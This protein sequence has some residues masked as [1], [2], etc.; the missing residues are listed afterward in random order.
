MLASQAL[1]HLN[2]ST[3]PQ[4]FLWTII[5]Y[6]SWPVEIKWGARY[7]ILSLI[8]VTLKKNQKTNRNR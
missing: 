3:I 5:E 8:V 7:G 2:H 4:S 6:L 1:Y